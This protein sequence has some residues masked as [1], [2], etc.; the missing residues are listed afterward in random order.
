MADMGSV[1]IIE[2]RLIYWRFAMVQK[3][4]HA[5]FNEHLCDDAIN[6]RHDQPDRKPVHQ[7]K[8]TQQPNRRKTLKAAHIHQYSQRRDHFGSPPEKT[9]K[10]NRF[11]LKSDHT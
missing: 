3:T 4:V 7:C 11:K 10:R 6:D 2:F 9:L 1:K 8:D 5:V